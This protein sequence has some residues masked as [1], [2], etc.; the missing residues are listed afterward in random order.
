MAALSLGE[1]FQNF[2][3][4]C[5]ARGEVLESTSARSLQVKSSQVKKYSPGYMKQALRRAK[6][7]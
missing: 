2:H 1:S 4:A 6:I 7:K 5:R 3:T